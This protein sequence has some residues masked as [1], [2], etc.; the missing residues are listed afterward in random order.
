MNPTPPFDSAVV[1]ALLLAIVGLAGVIASFFGIDEALFNEKAQRVVD[2]LLLL[3]TAGGIFWALYGRLFMRTP[4][5]TQAAVK[6]TMK[7]EGIE[8]EP[9]DPAHPPSP[10]QSPALIGII[11]ILLT[12]AVLAGCDTTPTRLPAAAQ[13]VQ[14]ACARD[15]AYSAIRCAT[16]IPQV[17]EVYQVSILDLVKDPT[18]EDGVKTRLRQLDAAA[19]PVMAT[20]LG[21]IAEYSAVQTAL[22][23]GQTTEEQ[24]RIANQNL[25]AWVTSALPKIAALREALGL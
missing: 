25:E 23:Q 18:V 7:H 20:G 15:E 17:Y 1:K 10:P 22:A 5:L 21:L 2:A 6:A 4:P 14:E 19:S 12:V 16:S 8:E 13:V 3:A 11:A 9:Y 24:L